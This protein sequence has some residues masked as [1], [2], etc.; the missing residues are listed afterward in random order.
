[1]T[2]TPISLPAGVP[3]DDAWPTPRRLRAYQIVIWVFAALLLLMGEGTLSRARHA[4]QTIG[5]DAAPSIIASQE[6]G[7]ALADLDANAANYLIGT[8]SH[9]ADAMRAYE[10][11][12][13]QATARLVDT[14]ENITYGDAE[15]V[16]IHTMIEELGRYFELFA[17]ARYRHDGGDE[18]GA[19]ETYRA[20]T[21]LMH[22][23]ILVAANQLDRANRSYMDEIYEDQRRAS[24][25]A[26]GLAVVLG[27]ALLVALGLAQLFILKK[28]RRILNPPLAVATLLAFGF[29]VYLW[30]AFGDAR[31]QLKI[32]KED[33]FE[34]IHTLW[35]ARALAYD[36][37][38]DESRYLLDRA[39]AA[40]QEA[41]FDARVREL[42]T[43]PARKTVG[44]PGSFQGLFADELGNVTFAGERKAAEAMVARFAEY[45]EID[46]RIR[47]LEKAGNHAAAV[48]L[49]IGSL[50]TQSNAA[51]ERFDD[52]LMKTIKIN[53]DAF[54]A[55]ISD[56][57]RLLARAEW[58]DPLVVIAICALG[59]FGIRARLRE[60]V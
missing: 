2:A 57:D 44:T 16:P 31:H 36:A 4:L 15:K 27:G 38:G 29:I 37:N 11:R 48:D 26:E 49:C 1:M 3:R 7:S 22:T 39:A 32:A 41:S 10:T 25:G 5:H 20:A 30:H 59:W 28:M 52:A 12:R 43:A 19:L 33:A 42:T 53:R 46:R 14:A 50:S 51:F 56:G 9:R 23:R 47:A 8:A 13:V 58:L 45:Y 54:D 6:I 60:Y 34:S 55:T 40:T 21:T 17:E 18:K 24:Q 35:K